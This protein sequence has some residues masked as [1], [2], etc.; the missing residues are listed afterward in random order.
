MGGKPAKMAVS[1][2]ILST[3]F[4]ACARGALLLW[5]DWSFAAAKRHLAHVQRLGISE[6]VSYPDLWFVFLSLSRAGRSLPGGGES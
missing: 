2:Q 4:A 5:L 3:L 1:L 6:E